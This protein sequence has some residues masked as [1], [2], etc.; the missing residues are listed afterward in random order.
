M[1]SDPQNPV[2]QPLQCLTSITIARHT[3]D[4]F[5]LAHVGKPNMT[6]SVQY[7]AVQPLIEK[8]ADINAHGRFDEN[9]Q[10]SRKHQMKFT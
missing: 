10:Y 6:A 5:S 9:V 8:G 4:A 2:F 3:I 7:K 1:D